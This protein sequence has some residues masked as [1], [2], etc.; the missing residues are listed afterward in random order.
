VDALLATLEDDHGGGNESRSCTS[1]KEQ[2]LAALV[3]LLGGGL[4][5]L[6]RLLRS[7]HHRRGSVRAHAGS[8]HGTDGGAEAGKHSRE[9]DY[10]RTSTLPRRLFFGDIGRKPKARGVR[11]FVRENEYYFGANWIRFLCPN[12]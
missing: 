5:S 12:R 11:V 4:G 6:L 3:R 9:G 10:E 1:N 7:T 8:A 2:M